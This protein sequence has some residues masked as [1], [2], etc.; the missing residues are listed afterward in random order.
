[1]LFRS[2]LHIFDIVVCNKTKSCGENVYNI[3]EYMTMDLK[4]VVPDK[5]YLSSVKDAIAEYKVAP[6]KFEIQAVS[7]MVAAEYNDFTDYFENCKRE[8]LGIN[9]KQGRVAHTTFWLV[10]NDIY[11]GTFNLRHSLTPA[12]ERVGG[13][14]AYQI[15]PSKYHQGYACAGLQLCLEE[16]KKR[17]L[18]KVLITCDSTNIASYNLLKKALR[19]YRGIEAPEVEIIDGFEKRIWLFL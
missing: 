16:A 7:K 17:G 3:K 15:R 1:M 5:K 6:S 2:L 4:L 9:L 12:L 14:I 13:H 10:D 19:E 18:E 8:D 11:I